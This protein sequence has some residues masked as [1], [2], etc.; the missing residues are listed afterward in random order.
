MKNVIL[1]RVGIDSFGAF[2]LFKNFIKPYSEEHL[3]LLV[4]RLTAVL[5]MENVLIYLHVLFV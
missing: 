5:Q 2:L 1:I 4:P 3:S